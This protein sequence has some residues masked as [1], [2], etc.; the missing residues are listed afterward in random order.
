VAGGGALTAPGAAQLHTIRAVVL[1]TLRV[2]PPAPIIARAANTRDTLP[3]DIRIEPGVR[4][5]PL[6]RNTL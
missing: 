5:V 2:Y 3:G 4:A 1:E 6:T